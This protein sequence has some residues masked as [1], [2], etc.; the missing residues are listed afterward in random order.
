MSV[1]SGGETE[2]RTQERVAP[3][4][5]FKMMKIFIEFNQGQNLTIQ[6]KLNKVSEIFKNYKYVSE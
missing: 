5:V 3:L 4:P 2:I 6:I 1:N